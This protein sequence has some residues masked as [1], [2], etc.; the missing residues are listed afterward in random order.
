M[1]GDQT[2]AS[3]AAFEQQSALSNETY[4]LG[5]KALGEGLS[6]LTNAYQG[7]GYDQSAKYS[8]MQSMTM[9]QTAGSNR[10]ARAQALA[11]VTAQKITS[12]LDE[13]TKIRSML[14]GQGLQTTNLAEQAGHQSSSDLS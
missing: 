11:G 1:S 2:T 6:Y 7:G 12:G 5:S 10:A 8:A 14:A 13:M 9:D 3:R 4:D